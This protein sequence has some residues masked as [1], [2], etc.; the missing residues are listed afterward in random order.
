M[1]F[2]KRTCRYF[3]SHILKIVMASNFRATAILRGVEEIPPIDTPASACFLLKTNK[4]GLKYRLE[5]DKVS[6]ITGLRLHLGIRSQNG[7]VVVNMVDSPIDE[8]VHQGVITEEDFVGNM[9]GL[10]LES[11]IKEIK[12]GHVYVN[13][14]TKEHSDGFLRGQIELIEMPAPEVRMEPEMPTS[15]SNKDDSDP[16][17]MGIDVSKI[18]VE[19]IFGKKTSKSPSTGYMS[20]GGGRKGADLSSFAAE[21]AGPLGGGLNDFM[22]GSPGGMQMGGGSNFDDYLSRPSRGRG[23]FRGG[24]PHPGGFDRQGPPPGYER[25][26]EPPGRGMNGPPPGHRHRQHRRH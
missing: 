17:F 1:D 19:D 22:S 3:F 2:W 15:H 20:G 8:S 24:R 5:T 4:H 10:P 14:C 6:K 26:G 9:Q 25:R 16:D 23:N 21:M 11:L 18:N 7:S 13:L 12:W